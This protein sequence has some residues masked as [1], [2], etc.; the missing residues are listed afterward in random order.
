M[1]K[2][3]IIFM[4]LVM[5][6]G[7][8][9]SLSATVT[10]NIPGDKT[11]LSAAIT[12]L[13]TIGTMDDNYVLNLVAN[14]PQTTPAGGY[15]ITATGTS[16]YSI[17]LEGNGNVITAYTPQASGILH[18]SI[19]EIRGG[20]YITIQNFVMQEN[21]VNTIT[22]LSTNNMTEFGV[23]VF[24]AS[25]SNGAKYVTIQN[26]TI[27][28]NRQYPNSFGIYANDRHSATVVTTAA[29]IASAAGAHDHLHIYGNQISNINIGIV[30]VGS[31]TAA[32]TPVGLDIGGSAPETGNTISDFGKSGDFSNY[33]TVTKYIMGILINDHPA[34][35][36][37]YNSI[38][39]SYGG[40]TTST[41]LRGIYVTYGGTKPTS[42][43][44]YRT[45][46]HN[47][48]SLMDGSNNQLYG[49]YLDQ[50]TRYFY[51]DISYN[52]FHDMGYTTLL[53][54]SVPVNCIYNV[55]QDQ[56]A[57]ISHNTFTNLNMN[58]SADVYL[59]FHSYYMP[60]ASST[61][62]ITHNHIVGSLTKAS[63]G[64]VYCTFATA[65]N[66]GSF[67]FQYN[68]FSNINV[69]GSTSVNGI[70]C[71]TSNTAKT[72]KNNTFS[73]WTVESGTSYPIYVKFNS[74]NSEISG[75]TIH[76]ITSSGSVDCITVDNSPTG[77][78]V[79]V[80]GNDI[81]DIT[82]TGGARG[83]V[84][85]VY[86]TNT[87]TL[88]VVGNK[89]HNLTGTGT[90]GYAHGI[91]A[92]GHYANVY[93]NMVYDLKAPD[94]TSNTTPPVC[95]IIVSAG[96]TNQI[97]YNSVYLNASGSNPAFS[98]A[99]IYLSGGETNEIRN[100]IFVNKSIPGASGYC[101]AL[102]K[103]SDGTTYIGPNSN[104]NIYFAGTPDANHLI[105]LF[106]S[107][108]YSTLDLYKAVL[109]DRDQ[110]S[111][112]EDVPW[113]ST[114]KAIDL[115]IDP[116][117]P[118]LVEGNAVSLYPDHDTDF[119]GDDR[120]DLTPDIGADE[121]DFRS[122]GESPVPVELSSFTATISTQ[123]Y[124][125]LTWVSQTE[126]G[127]AGYYIYRANCDQ[128]S[129]AQ[130]VSPM[131]PATNT[132]QMHTYK[133]TDEDIYETGTY[134]YWLDCAELGGSNQFYGYVSI[135]FLSPGDNPTPEIPLFTELKPIYPNPFN[136][137][138]TIPFSLAKDCEVSFK[139]YN[140]RGQIVKHFAVGHKKAGIYRIT[141]DGTDY[142]GKSLS[143]GV[144]YILM[145][146]GTDTYL[147]KA[148]LLK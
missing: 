120:N 129:E 40:V 132:S 63:G 11:D 136:P 109:S 19:F 110:N 21:P 1:N 2:P 28:L 143:T 78:T 100:N 85:Q 139:I 17:T 127:M 119:D 147:N 51:V 5:M 35:N 84:Y 135:T 141:W 82:S 138:A 81:Y 89:V 67:N 88:D 99:A 126:T 80:I 48:V 47:S 145:S 95:G 15:I 44:H 74:T 92:N 111:F 39:S 116:N 93:N 103:S 130:L 98:A 122:P 37:S 60:Q 65:G 16:D 72:V 102:W 105:G 124:V 58:T 14:N 128:L 68:D 90:E 18:D 117:V 96:T 38:T 54:A 133:F 46:S 131:I 23:A 140:T 30:S 101:A 50:G 25:T 87:Y 97:H 34:F 107:S 104:N 64:I 108:G 3:I 27:S 86:A 42:G 62:T 32:R 8:F 112:T 73:N 79:S 114:S 70:W 43:T 24:Y 71:Q 4:F 53:P 41:T 22:A 75:N 26:N 113:I 49:I 52:D 6:L 33:I 121:G 137:L 59:I 94:T 10:W 83:I 142:R 148:V 76:A 20:D 118:T 144:Y 69:V 9:T 77:V 146:D 7:T 57:T 61:Q 66:T 91:V 13:N 12:D 56:S 125:S 123:N 36:V 55:S 29:D 45:I 106:G 115:H 31:Y 134:Y